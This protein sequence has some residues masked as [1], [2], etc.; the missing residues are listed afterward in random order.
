QS[1]RSAIRFESRQPAP[2]QVAV[3]SRWRLDFTLGHSWLNP[4]NPDEVAVD[5]EITTPSGSVELMP[6]YYYQDYERFLRKNKEELEAIGSPGWRIDYR[7]RNPGTYRWKL[8]VTDRGKP[9][10]SQAAGEFTATPATHPGYIKRSPTKPDLLMRDDGSSYYP[11]GQNLCQAVDL[12]EPFPY[13]FKVQPDQGSY[14]YDRYIQRMAEA[15]M[16]LARVWMT[17]WSY[18]LEGNPRWQDFHGQGRYNLANAWRLDHL[19]DDSE[20]RGI[21]ILLTTTHMSEFNTQWTSKAWY[22]SAMNVSN[23]GCLRRADD[24]FTSA[25]VMK[26]YRHRM[27]YLVARWGSRPNIVAWEFFG[28]TNLMPGYTEALSARWHSELAKFVEQLDAGRHLIFTHCHNWQEGHKLWA[29]PEIDCVQGNGYIRPPNH[30]PNHVINYDNYLQEVVRYKK[31]VLVAEFG[32]RSE[33]GAPSFDYLEAQLHSGIWASLVEPFAGLALH[34][35]WNFVDGANLYP[36]YRGLANFAAGIDRIAHDYRQVKPTIISARS[37]L[38]AAGM[39]DSNSGFYWIYDL[40]IFENWKNVPTTA[41]ARIELH[42]LKPGL[43]RLE[44]WDTMAGKTV[45]VREETLSADPTIA[46]PPVPRDLAL[47]IS[48]RLP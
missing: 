33:L 28:E 47:K 27:R 48:L 13:P 39:Q 19:L 2:A 10:G 43:Y 34:W 20:K 32:G 7:P 8:L 5:A 4:F 11:I 45:A 31:P 42:N 30:T 37:R 41:N 21:D 46:L 18:G 16:N 3:M 29:L 35:W 40:E 38:A 24:F 12:Q 26:Q 6:A 22:D 17:P 23:G 25:E 1:T 15:G 14:T 9:V 44:F 36:H